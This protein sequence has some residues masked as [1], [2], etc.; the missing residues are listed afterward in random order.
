MKGHSK[1]K[2]GA[3]LAAGLLCALALGGCS[4]RL[5]RAIAR[6][7]ALRGTQQY[8]AA[9]TAYEIIVADARGPKAAEVWLRI[10]DLHYY[11]LQSVER[12]VEAYQKVV[13][14]W[15]WQPSAMTAYRRLAELHEARRDYVAAIESLEM[16]LQYF[17]SYPE[18]DAVRHTIGT[19][20]MQG[21]NFDQ[22]QVEFRALL[23]E[24]TLLP[25]VRAAVL[26]D[27]AESHLMSGA[28]RDAIRY[29]D[30]LLADFSAHPLTRRAQ[31]QR[32]ASYEE[33]GEQP[34]KASP[35]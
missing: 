27:L 30:Q 14:E 19:Y 34:A 32:A 24:P 3:G 26:F 35:R 9:L 11:N 21:K 15:P 28:P 22:A 23:A 6:A 29:Y 10:G 12:A 17:P 4:S 25:D 5:E 1:H 20:Y 31:L 16:L 13:T 8:E 2:C 7:D 33:L 18:R